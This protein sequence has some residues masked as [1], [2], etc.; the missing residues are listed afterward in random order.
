MMGVMCFIGGWTNVQIWPVV[1]CWVLS[2]PVRLIRD[3]RF[4]ELYV[5]VSIVE[6][7]GYLIKLHV[8]DTI[9]CFK[10]K[11]ALPRVVLFVLFKKKNQ[12]HLLCEP[13]ILSSVSIRRSLAEQ[14]L[15]VLFWKRTSVTTSS[16]C[17]IRCAVISLY[18]RY[19]IH[20]AIAEFWVY[21]GRLSSTKLNNYFWLYIWKN[22][23]INS[24]LKGSPQYPG[25]A[26]D[27]KLSAS[28]HNSPFC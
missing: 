11:Q 7:N 26:L 28:K 1:Y 8:E 16:S 13:S 12:K 22:K 23:N 25:W 19:N 4:G 10:I 15:L 2:S 21:I 3:R 5:Y 17:F 24:F 9:C 27:I 18:L 6:F 14:T 20:S